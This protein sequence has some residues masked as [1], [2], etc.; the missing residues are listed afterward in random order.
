[1][2][3]IESTSVCWS[4]KKLTEVKNVD[5]RNKVSMKE[6]TQ[7][8][9]GQ[10]LPKKELVKKRVDQRTKERLDQSKIW[11]KKES[12]REK[13]N[14]RNSRRKKEF[15]KEKVYQRKS[16]PQRS[17]HPQ[18]ESRCIQQGLI[19][20]PHSPASSKQ[21]NGDSPLRRLNKVE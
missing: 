6:L 4:K 16:Y 3:I 13:V 1:M 21:V 11:P 5:Q 19:R 9:V 14:Q 2:F 15:T 20:V 12:T 17:V 8:R 7:E 18:I 10:N